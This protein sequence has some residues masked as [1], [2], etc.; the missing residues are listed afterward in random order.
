MNF[1]KK[2]IKTIQPDQPVALTAVTRT[3]QIEGFSIPGI[4][5][6]M[7]YHFTDLQVYS[8]GLI[9]CWGMVDL[10]MFKNK[11]SK[12]WVVT[13]IPDGQTIS[14]FSLGS[15]VIENGAWDYD[16]ESFYAYVKKLIKTLNPTL[17]NLYNY[18]G[19]NYKMIGKSSVAKHSSLNSKPYYYD[20][21]DSFLSKRN[22]GEKFHVFYRND[23]TK[24]YLAELSLYK[25][26]KIEI[27][28]LPVKKTFKFEEIKDLIQNEKL[29]TELNTGEKITI[30][31][32]GS[33]T[34]KSGSG[35]DITAKYNEFEDKYSELNG[36]EN[37]ISKCARIFDAYK[38]D[39]SFKLKQ[40][41]KEAYEKV[42]E[43]QRMFVGDM[44]TKDYEVRQIIYGDS[45]KK[46]WEDHYGFEYPYD[47]M[48]EPEK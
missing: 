39:P 24:T 43:H 27:T 22:E 19:E 10:P 21:P 9:S 4:I 45:I 36:T 30:L 28:N 29:I 1:F 33:F 25:T 40:E 26:G 13:S 47:D 31:G 16:E 34:V 2:I 35:V 17:E 15:W 11:L 37:S 23:D 3:E 12:S 32:L 20:N 6:N 42:P 8:D 18:N 46:E 38:L 14:I 48:P 7:Q 44:D 5:L 41:L